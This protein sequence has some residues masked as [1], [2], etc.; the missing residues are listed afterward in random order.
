MIKNESFKKNLIQ[1]NDDKY[2][3]N[4]KYKLINQ[5][6]KKNIIQL[7]ID[8][9]KS[10][11]FSHNKNNNSFISRNILNISS[12][13]IIQKNASI[14]YNNQ[15]SS[16]EKINISK[17]LNKSIKIKKK[18]INQ[19]S[20]NSRNSTLRTTKKSFERIPKIKNDANTYA[21][22]I[23]DKQLSM[24]SIKNDK[25]LLNKTLKNFIMDK[26]YKN[27]D[28]KTIKIFQYRKKIKGIN[29]SFSQDSIYNFDK[30]LYNDFAS[31][32]FLYNDSMFKVPKEMN[33]SKLERV[34]KNN[35]DS[36]KKCIRLKE[37]KNCK[38][39]LKYKYIINPN[40]SNERIN[41]KEFSKKIEKIGEKTDKDIDKIVNSKTINFFSILERSK[42]NN[43]N[44]NF[45]FEVKISNM[46]ETSEKD[47]KN[48]I[49]E[50]IFNNIIQLLD[51]V[52][53]EAD[54]IKEDK[55][56][57]KLKEKQENQLN[58]K[59]PLLERFKNIII[60]ISSFLKTRNISES[61]LRNYKL[62][63]QSF[64]YPET[65]ELINAIKIKNL[66]LCY[67]I[68]D[69]HKYIV[70]DFDYFYLTPL[71]W[72]VKYNFYK[73]LPTLLDYGS[74]LDTCCFSGET[75]LHIS[76]KNNYYDC[77]CI[78]L[79]YLASPFIKDKNGKKPIDLT[80]DYDMKYL[81]K[82][83]MELHY[84]SYF[85]KTSTQ[86]L[87]IQS[88]LWAFIK[89]KFSHKLQKEVMDYFNIKRITDIF[90]LRY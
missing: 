65:S 9:N 41:I 83:I 54:K 15:F 13:K 6:I 18:L 30:K 47:Y 67:H 81:L 48:V 50:K 53:E 63:D 59:K 88:G 21:K 76:I 58:T 19:S 3:S 40:F 75:P 49:N 71:H 84:S 23:N 10:N 78:L 55:I 46:K 79:Y 43:N 1:I 77:V 62:I 56:I 69:N 87:Y 44:H 5:N 33:S 60:K 22:S 38:K 36:I 31:K 28:N 57:Q 90:T 20:Y 82:K 85:Q 16:L 68:I 45:N 34:K 2:C 8:Y 73:F 70:L 39:I 4:K 89:E 64:S 12:K 26:D 66:D 74:P 42:F 37:M 27:K 17:Y 72:A 7:P 14:D 86:Y 35:K 11:I 24:E 25:T 32:N 29:S 51:I 80:N 61:E 52:R